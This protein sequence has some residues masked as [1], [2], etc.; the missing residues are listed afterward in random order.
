MQIQIIILLILI[1][2]VL[3]YYVNTCDYELFKQ[4]KWKKCRICNRNVNDVYM[5]NFNKHNIT[6]TDDND[7]DIYLPCNYN[8][9]SYEI[10]KFIDYSIDSGKSNVDKKIFIIDNCDQ[11]THKNKIWKN[12][13]EYYG[14]NTATKYMPMTYILP[15]DINKLKKQYIK[16]NIYIL[17][18]NIQRQQGLLITKSL[19]NIISSS[20][21]GY[22]IAQILLQDPYTI[23]GRKINLRVY[24]AIICIGG[25]LN[26]YAFNDGFMYYTAESFKTSTISFKHNVTTGYI[27]RKVYKINPL[28]HKD[29]KKYL[30]NRSI[31]DID[32]FDNIYKLL[33]DIIKSCSDKLCKN[34]K[35]NK[36]TTYQLFGAD[37]ALDKSLKPLLMEINKGPDLGAKDERDKKLKQS[38]FEDLLALLGLIDIKRDNGFIKLM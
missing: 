27:D 18:K 23:N 2:S 15:S 7:Y 38:V 1:I 32:V 26:A 13:V 21:D 3:I 24:L 4:L 30:H 9:I 28:T 29:F 36:F 17:K 22:V 20:N 37:I 16:G 12:L 14:V 6:Q 8:N 5:H 10:S 35:L 19:N 11:L 33:G 31:N 25:E 34:D